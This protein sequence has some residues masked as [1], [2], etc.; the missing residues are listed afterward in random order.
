MNLKELAEKLQIS[1]STVSRVLNDKPG[2]SE[3]TRQMVLDAVKDTDF[4][5]NYNASNLANPRARFI[6]ILGRRRGGQQD[7]IYFHHSIDRFEE[8]FQKHGYQCIN[9][10]LFE[11]ETIS[12]SEIIKGSPLGEND[13]AGLIIRGQSI[14]AK[15]ILSFR[16]AGIPIVLLENKLQETVLDSVVCEDRESSYNLT[17]LLIKKGYPHIIHITGPEDWYNNKE[18]LAGYKMAIQEAGMTPEVV[19]LTETTVE[20]GEEAFS[21]IKGKYKDPMG[22]AAVNDA[23]AIGFCKAVRNEGLSIPEE[24]GITGFDDIPWAEHNYPPLTTAQVHIKE[25]GRLAAARLIQLMEEPE[26]HPVTIRV[27]T[28]IIE[29]KSTK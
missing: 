1:P 23:M 2:I 4:Q 13:F 18:R 15:T 19:T 17:N 29:R 16:K 12:L 11:D 26:S 14:P 10:G 21:Q 24:V 6:G 7:Q 28:V 27:P 22:V 20:T 8:Y 3:K 25:M 5:Q 9:L